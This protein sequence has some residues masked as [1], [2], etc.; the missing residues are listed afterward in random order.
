[1]IKKRIIAYTLIGAMTIVMINAF[2]LFGAENDGVYTFAGLLFYVFG[3]W[4]S[5]ILLKEAKNG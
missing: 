5:V 1:M 4:A 2:E 3:I